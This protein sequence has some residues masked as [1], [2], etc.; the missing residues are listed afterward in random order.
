M[1]R[2]WQSFWFFGICLAS[3]ARA[4]PD[5][6]TE[7][8]PSGGTVEQWRFTELPDGTR[9]ALGRIGSTERLALCATLS[10]ASPSRDVR[11]DIKTLGLLV[12][13]DMRAA[14]LTSRLKTKADAV[15]HDWQPFQRVEGDRVVLCLGLPPAEQASAASALLDLVKPVPSSYKD[16]IDA[17]ARWRAHEG[18]AHVAGESALGEQVHELAWLGSREIPRSFVSLLR[19]P[20]GPEACE[21][22][23]GQT[24]NQFLMTLAGAGNIDVGSMESMVRSNPVLR[25]RQKVTHRVG[26]DSVPNLPEQ[27]YPRFVRLRRTD[28]EDSS[29]HVAWPLVRSSEEQQVTLRMLASV[30]EHRLNQRFGPSD[31]RRAVVRAYWE[32]YRGTLQVDISPMQ[33]DDL[34][35]TEQHV[36]AVV[37]QLRSGPATSAELA[38]ARAAVMNAARLTGDL[39][40]DLAVHLSREALVARRAPA[41][42]RTPEPAATPADLQHLAGQVLSRRNVAELLCEAAAPAG[43]SNRGRGEGQRPKGMAYVVKSGESL[44]MIAQRF[45]VTIPD[46]IRANRLHHP[47]QIAPGTRL[48]IPI[49]GSTTHSH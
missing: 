49:A 29:L 42:T 20:P 25:H 22:S 27:T 31:R 14:S 18:L 44:Q 5:A 1:R 41:T 10:A 11:T 7:P 32:G 36:F 45:R 13:L 16:C 2:L 6:G 15:T 30:I 12:D 39:A 28:R 38:S 17:L 23:K 37:E 21:H 35:N 47:D 43:P 34:A 8:S 24:T 9:L 26:S 46:L 33:Q 19:E 4:A 40:L 3:A 48:V